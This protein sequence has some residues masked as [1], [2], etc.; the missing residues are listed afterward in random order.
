MNTQISAADPH[1][2]QTIKALDSEMSYVDIGEGDPIIFLHGN[3]ES[4][5]IWRNV[6][7]H[8][9]GLGRVLAPDLI[10]F[11]RSGK[12]PTRSYRFTDHVR[13]LDAWFEALELTHN[14]TLVVHDWGSAL[15]FHRAARFPDHIQAIVH[16]E[17]I[18]MVRS[19]SDFGAMAETFKAFRSPKGE[20][21]VLDENFFVEKALPRFVMRKLT[22]DE[23]AVYRAPFLKREDRLPTL[24]FPREIPVEGEPADVSAVV[25]HYGEWLA[26]S[27]LPK[28]FI[29]A[30]PGVVMTGRNREFARTWKNQAEVTVRGLHCI[31]EDSPDDI[32]SAIAQFVRTQRDTEST[33]AP[34]W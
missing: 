7:P 12:S 18:A 30:E 24:V 29:N 10:G 5:Y 14:V 9:I 27:N 23:M 4:S 25:D 33:E 31:T 26:Q 34:A 3:P 11:G 28:L 2:R 13:Y 17:S 15:G 8:V 19:W 21:M 22:A 1:P 20:D 16:M 32:G 6:I